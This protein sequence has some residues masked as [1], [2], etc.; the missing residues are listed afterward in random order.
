MDKLKR[1]TKQ[2]A[3]L[4]DQVIAVDIPKRR[5]MRQVYKAARK[6]ADK[7]LCLAAAEKIDS[8]L[9]EDNCVFIITGFPIPPNN[10]C[11]TDGPP[12]AV[13]MAQTLQYYGF[14]PII[15]T[16][17]TCA[18][19][20]RAVSPRVPVYEMSAK[21]EL[22]D[23]E[24]EKLLDEYNPSLLFSVERPGWN[25]QKMYHTMA[26]LN[27]SEV[28]GKTD[29]LFEH[30]RR[31][32]ITTVAIGDGGNELGLGTI[33]D[34]IVKHVPYGAVCQCPCRGG[35]AAV[36]PADAL[37]IARVSNWGCYGVAA[38]LSLLKQISYEHNGEKEL[39]LLNCVVEAGGIDSVTK[40][41][42]PFVDGLSAKISSLVAQLIWQIANA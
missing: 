24:A 11:E 40:K 4:I 17:Q 5:G 34:A 29:Y 13:V 7:P 8:A 2:K 35:I 3:Y 42:K 6:M 26:G 12:G 27:I 16:D 36:T 28:V 14:E 21:Y 33:V 23:E 31:R 30:A 25:K 39:Q 20:V 1:D 41:A 9:K 38:C 32:G 37:V 19:I 22:A 10:V 15:I 18:K